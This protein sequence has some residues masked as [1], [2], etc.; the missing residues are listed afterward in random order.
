ME[1]KKIVPTELVYLT[2]GLTFRKYNIEFLPRERVYE[3]FKELKEFFPDYFSKFYFRKAGGRWYSR[4]LEDVLFNLLGGVIYEIEFKYLTFSPGSL[5]IV[6]EKLK[7]WYP[8]KEDQEKIQ[9]MAEKFYQ[10]IKNS[11]IR[12]GKM[13]ERI[14]EQIKK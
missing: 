11:I 5:K 10:V 9:E 2:L 6:P 14:I 12:R 13:I 7:E 3:R 4:E 8:K 1:S